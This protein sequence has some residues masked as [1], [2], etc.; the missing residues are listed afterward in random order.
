MKSGLRR[1]ETPEGTM[2]VLVLSLTRPSHTARASDLQLVVV[3]IS[4]DS[5]ITMYQ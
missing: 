2:L 3:L 4:F 5:L 1:C